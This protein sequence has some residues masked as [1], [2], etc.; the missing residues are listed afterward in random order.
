MHC[1]LR[2]PDVA[3]VILC[4]N[5][6]DHTKFEVGQPIRISYSVFTADTLRY[7]VAVTLTFDPLTVNVC[8]LSFMMWSNSVPNFSEIGQSV[9]K[10]C[11]ND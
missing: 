8:S 11:N 3:P 2:P 10:Y 5:Y 4:L 6:E 7:V 9:A 1:N